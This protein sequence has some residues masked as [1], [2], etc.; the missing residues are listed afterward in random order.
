[1]MMGMAP[2]SIPQ[3]RSGLRK[4]IVGSPVGWALP[5]SGAQDRWAM[6]THALTPIQGLLARVEEIAQRGAQG[7]IG[8]ESHV[9][10]AAV[11]ALLADALEELFHRPL[12]RPAERPRLGEQLL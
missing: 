7:L 8:E 10:I 2:S 1:M 3:A 12:I 4:V 5:T 6:P 9:V 11:A